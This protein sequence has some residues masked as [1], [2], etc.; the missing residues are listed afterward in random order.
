MREVLIVG[1]GNIAGGF[2]A[3]RGADTPPFTHAGAFAQHPDFAVAACVDPD[4]AQ[5]AAF[6]ERWQ[7]GEDAASIEAVWAMHARVSHCRLVTND[8]HMGVLTAMEIIYRHQQPA[9]GST[10][11]S[12]EHP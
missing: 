10:L 3:G 8:E 5:R 4:D 1:C 9:D 12:Q 7:V 11:D 6:A 2:D